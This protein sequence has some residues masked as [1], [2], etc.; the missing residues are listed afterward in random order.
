VFK[1]EMEELRDIPWQPS[2]QCS[3]AGKIYSLKSGAPKEMS[4]FVRGRIG[5]LGVNLT[6]GGK[7]R[8][9]SVHTLVALTW[10][11]PRPSPIHLVMHRDNNPANNADSNLQWGLPLHNSAQMVNDGRSAKGER[12]AG[13]K[14]T[15]DRVIS[16]RSRMHNGELPSLIAR[17]LGMALSTI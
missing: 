15:A 10:I 6:H 8:L 11:G 14:L 12:V 2:Y 1:T 16:I 9:H 13:A 4:L 5:H 17:E 3:R 7:Y